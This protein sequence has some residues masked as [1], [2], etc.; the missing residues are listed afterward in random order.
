[1]DG[2]HN[3]KYKV[4]TLNSDRYMDSAGTP[5]IADQTHDPMRVNRMYFFVV[6]GVEPR[7]LYSTRAVP[8]SYT[9][10]LSHVQ[11]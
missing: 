10:A 5:T 9:R 6:L 2:G 7:I 3:R 1:M 4:K 11:S 8:L